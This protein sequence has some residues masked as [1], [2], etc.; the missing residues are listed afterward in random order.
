MRAL[1]KPKCEE[2]G[3]NYALITSIQAGGF[4]GGDRS[5]DF[6]EG[7]NRGKDCLVIS[8]KTFLV[9]RLTGVAWVK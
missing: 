5:T 8:K 1:L 7:V 6:S 2:L 3:R 4:N 9:I